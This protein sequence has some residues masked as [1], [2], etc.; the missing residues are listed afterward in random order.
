MAREADERQRLGRAFQVGGARYDRLRPSYP[1]D[2]VRWLIGSTEP[3]RVVD[4]GA[5]TGKLTAQ[6]VELGHVVSAV[7]PSVDMADQLTA[8]LPD[9]AVSH[10]SGE[11]TGLPDRSAD[12]V[13][14]GQAWHWADPVAASAEAARILAVGGHLG[15]IWNFLDLR[16]ARM[17][18][19]DAASHDLDQGSTENSSSAKAV[20]A[21]FGEPEVRE[22]IW[23]LPAST[24]DLADRVTTRS[25]YLAADEQGQRHLRELCAETVEREFGPIGDTVVEV[26]HR[27]IAF[28]FAMA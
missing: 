28:R 27:T 15:L 5:G 10:G 12:V 8:H 18:A 26:P 7:E 16:D 1:I 22:F 11:A 4:V 25:Y 21:Q 6:I 3:L 17:A 9:V 2:A 20:G 14:Y 24:R 19:L 23:S 13:V